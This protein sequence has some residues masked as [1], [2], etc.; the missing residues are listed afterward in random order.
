MEPSVFKRA[1]ELQK[2]NVRVKR[3]LKIVKCAHAYRIYGALNTAVRGKDDN[4]HFG[5]DTMNVAHQGYAVGSR[6][7]EVNDRQVEDLIPYEFECVF[8]FICRLDLVF[9]LIE[10]SCPA[11]REGSDR[12]RRSIFFPVA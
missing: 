12:H 11:I 3:F 5:I 4:G 9:E 7:P 8:A 10:G 6:Q 1:F 2:Q